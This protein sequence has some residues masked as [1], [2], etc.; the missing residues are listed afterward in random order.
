MAKVSAKNCV[1]LV[2]GYV[3]STYTTQ[4]DASKS[5]DALDA[6][7]FSDGSKNFIPGI[8]IS[9]MT[10]N[11]LWDS[12]TSKTLERMSLLTAGSNL[13]LIP[14]GY[15][16][17]A[18]TI[19]MPYMQANFTPTGS[20]TSLV[21]IGSIKFANYGNTQG[22]EFGQALY[23]GTITA[24][25]TGTAVQ[26]TITPAS[27]LTSCAAAATL[28]IWTACATDTYA[29]VVQHSSDGSTSWSTIMTFA[30]TGAAVT[31]ERQTFAA[32]A[33]K[34]YRRYLATRTGA[35]GNTLGFTVHFWRD[36]TQ[37]T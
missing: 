24:T 26:D 3:F 27:D 23:H 5:V 28:H 8:G 19:S 18:K 31:S 4:F 37:S 21:G 32:A 1:V 35:A 12:T 17:G 34:R 9:E 16:A 29:I 30:A 33:L 6:T 13:T 25:S 36:P 10:L 7:G 14:E 11:M 20:P 22:V 15:T 2:G